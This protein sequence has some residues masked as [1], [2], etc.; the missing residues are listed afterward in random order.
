MLDNSRH[1]ICLFDSEHRLV[2]ANRLAA[3]LMGIDEAVLRPGTD[4]HDIIAAQAAAG[5]FGPPEAA[6]PV[7]RQVLA[8]DRSRPARYHRTTPEGVVLDV[9][10]DPLPDGGFVISFS[11]VTPLMQAEAEARRR[12]AQA[13]AMLDTM[14]HGIVLVDAGNRVVAANA[15]AA[16]YTGLT[17]A[18]LCP[19]ALMT[20]LRRLQFERGEFGTGPEAEAFC[21]ERQAR[22]PGTAERYV[23]RRPTGQLIEVITDRTP[24]GGFVRT[25]T[26][27]TETH[28]NRAAL[29]QAEEETRRRA[30]VQRAMLD[31]IR[32]GVVL[33]DRDGRLIAA[34]AL[35][36]QLTLIPAEHLTP[37]RHVHELV[38]EQARRGY[39]RPGE[40]EQALSQLP[41]DDDWPAPHRFV[42]HRAD[43]RVLEIATDRTPDGG[44]IRTYSDVTDTVRT[45]EEL[46]R[47]RD[48]AEEASRAKSRFLATMSHELRTPLNAVIGFSEALL[49]QSA[50]EPFNEYA[51]TIHAAGRQLLAL[52]DDIL[53]VAR[54]DTTAFR[55]G[56]APVELDALAQAVL[57]TARGAGLPPGVTLRAEIGDGLPRIAGDE[58]RLRQVLGSLLSN[59][60]K[61]TPAGG[62]VL[63]RAAAAPDG[64]VAVAVVDHGVG[65]APEDIPRAFEPFTQLD[66]A[67]ARQFQGSG[68]GLHLAR[69][70]A[71]AMGMALTLDSRPGQGTTA[72]LTIP[73]DRLVAGVPGAK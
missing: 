11:D 33:F 70:L 61:F 73:P 38:A 57:R 64:A 67:A 58:R 19:G 3:R 43:G 68:L 63:L 28:R 15:L 31:N 23:R 30:A 56:D 26:D 12:A 27:V 34:N 7:L 2:A 48:A 35:A 45:R 20:E 44:Y 52:I 16:E 1:G 71:R 39:F 72:T 14:R 36:A 54:A 51:H 59:A 46:E 42:R 9:A 25:Y 41:A 17:V 21:A 6:A 53:E 32:H 55:P 29:E 65:M 66:G 4:S 49:N 47:A 5:A 69:T 60:I 13:Q 10:S 18:E 22:P 37:G 50:P 40:V 8:R 24:D 62:E